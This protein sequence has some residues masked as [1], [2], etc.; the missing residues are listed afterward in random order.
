MTTLDDS[1]KAPKR[2]KNSSKRAVSE[3]VPSAQPPQAAGIPPGEQVGAPPSRRRR[4]FTKLKGVR[5]GLADVV[6]RLEAGAPADGT[7]DPKRA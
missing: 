2:T 7:I 1:Q 6:H 4:T 5:L 3:T